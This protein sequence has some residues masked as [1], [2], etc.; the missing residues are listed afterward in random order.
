PSRMRWVIL[1]IAVLLIAGGT[2]AFLE[3]VVWNRLPSAL[4]GRWEVVHG[5]REYKEAVFEFYRSGK[6][7]GHV[8]DKENLAVISA[9]VRVEG[10]KIYTTTRHPRTG[11]KHV[12]VQTIRTLTAHELVIEDEKG[13]RMTMRRAD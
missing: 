8:N 5:P 13:N 12:S 9:E 3:L 7:V 1:G 6:M 4:V 2:W 11:Q 10:D